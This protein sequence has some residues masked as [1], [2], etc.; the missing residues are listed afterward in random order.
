[1]SVQG[2]QLDSSPEKDTAKGGHFL[3]EEDVLSG[4][5]NDTQPT[6]IEAKDELETKVGQFIMLH[7]N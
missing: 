6:I 2:T 7:S 3:R 1:M 4:V 5:D